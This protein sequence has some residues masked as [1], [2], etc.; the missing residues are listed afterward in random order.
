MSQCRYSAKFYSVKT[1]LCDHNFIADESGSQI[2]FD[3]IDYSV[4]HFDYLIIDDKEICALEEKSSFH[5]SISKAKYSALI[6]CPDI[7]FNE[8]Q[9]LITLNPQTPIYLDLKGSINN[10]DTYLLEDAFVGDVSI[11]VADQEFLT[12]NKFIVINLGNS[13]EEWRK[14]Q[15]FGSVILNHPLSKNHK[16]GESVL[17]YTIDPSPTPTPSI[18]P[19]HT[20]TPTLTVTPTQSLTPS[21]TVTPT[22]TPTYSLTPTQ[23]ITPSLTVTPTQ[24]LTPSLTVTPTNSLTPTQ[25]ITPSLTVTPTQSLTPSLTVTPTNS[26]TPTPTITPS[27]TVTPTQSLTPSLT[28]TPTNSLT[29]TPTI[30]PSLTV[31]PTQSLTPSLTVTPTNSLTP[32]PTI[33]PS[34][35]VTPT[36]SLTPSLTVTP[37]NSLTPTQTITPSLTVTPTQTQ[38]PSQTITP[39]QTAT[40]S[41]TPTITHTPTHTPTPT[42]SPS[43]WSNYDGWVPDQNDL[44]GGEE[45][46]SNWKTEEDIVLNPEGTVEQWGGGEVGTFYAGNDDDRKPTLTTLNGLPAINFDGREDGNGDYLNTLS[47]ESPLYTGNGVDDRILENGL[48]FFIAG[49]QDAAP[50]GFGN[51]DRGT[52]FRHSSVWITSHAPWNDGQVY[53]DLD[54]NHCY[55]AAGSDQ[56]TCEAN[57]GEWHTRKRINSTKWMQDRAGNQITGHY[58]IGEWLHDSVNTTQQVWKNGTLLVQ[59][60]NSNPTLHIK[61]DANIRLAQAGWHQKVV[62]GEI[63]ILDYYPDQKKREKIEGYLG[64]KWRF[65]QELDPNH[66]FLN[67]PPSK[68]DTTLLQPVTAGSNELTVHDQ[69]IF[70]VGDFVQIDAGKSNEEII[71]VDSFGSL[72]LSSNLQF[73]HYAGASIDKFIP[74]TPS[75]TVTPTLTPTPSFTPTPTS[76]IINCPPLPGQLPYKLCD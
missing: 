36:Q 34:L 55:G 68:G 8:I 38:T 2:V 61:P 11:E 42:V 1:I 58:F 66:P 5:A 27:L 70:N 49:Y 53:F 22:F 47:N 51:Y 28:V 73:D 65:P 32:T 76:S 7:P 57:G 69:S 39:T 37:T 67:F 13:N 45:E 59:N 18:T 44:S 43:P 29:P 52:I 33:T 4:P 71:Q 35:T 17:M 25:T 31:T 20:T 10:F 3:N 19:T 6:N 23:T 46:N 21:L 63:I 14:I 56:A 48:A 9:H 40:I 50:D 74:P 15:D 12:K 26:L 64:H 72:I 24:S 75:S 41:I 62:M 16:K 60:T 30:T 54:V